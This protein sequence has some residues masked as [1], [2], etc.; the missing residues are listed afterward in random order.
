MVVMRQDLIN[1][2]SNIASPLL[3]K[4]MISKT[5]IRLLTTL[6]ALCVSISISDVK[7]QWR[8]EHASPDSNALGSSDFQGIT[9]QSAIGAASF[10]AAFF[11]TD[12]PTYLMD[13]GDLAFAWLFVVP[14]ATTLGT[15][16][17]YSV[18]SDVPPPAAIL[19]AAAGSFLGCFA[20]ALLDGE[21][22]NTFRPGRN[23]IVAGLCSVACTV[24]LL[25]LP[26]YGDWSP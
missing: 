8:Y 1:V 22:F 20:G 6:L 17:T 12:G 26:I 10:A 5:K 19:L 23:A 2:R 11:I 16:I 25:N 15:V 21:L 14:A 7:A 18:L 4:L 9:I 13:K 3:F 24:I